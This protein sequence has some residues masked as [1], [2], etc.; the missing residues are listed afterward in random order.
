MNATAEYRYEPD[1]VLP[2]GETLAEVLEQLEMTQTDLARRT[3]LSV[4]H[5]N[6]IVNGAASVT[7]ETALVLE[8]AT[9]VSTRVWNSLEVAYREHVSR[10][11]EDERLASDLDWL[12]EL[13]I[14]ELIRRGCIRNVSRPIDLLREVCK[15]FGV[16]NR[17]TWE[18]VWHKPTAYRTSRAFTS[19]PGA[20]AAWLRI[21]EQRASEMECDPFDKAGLS[22][23]LQEL[24]SLTCEA[25][26]AVWWP[27]L[28]ELCARVGVAVIAEPEIKGARINGAARWLTSEKAIVQ[29]SLRHRWSDIFWFTLFHELAHLLIHSK[30]DAFINDTGGHSG[31]E[32]EADAFASQILIPRKF[33]P[34]LPGLLTT[35]DVMAFADRIGVM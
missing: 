18:A 22:S 33:G 32:Q 30:R 31:V 4:K 9:G 11:E 27:Q 5:V 21:G 12:K 17:A 34:E 28:V 13:P 35:G 14:K 19:N 15:F 16:A 2:P 3:G 7:P 20:I 10:Q 8:R 25:D 24:R 23:T 6:Q 1:V 29:L 26:P